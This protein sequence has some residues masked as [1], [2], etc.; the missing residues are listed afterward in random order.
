M[1]PEGPCDVGQLFLA[2]AS[3]LQSQSADFPG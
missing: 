2:V 1:G 3:S